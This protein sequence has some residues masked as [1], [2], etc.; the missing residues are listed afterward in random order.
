MNG[1]DPPMERIFDE[2][3][4]TSKWMER[5][6]LFLLESFSLRNESMVTN[7]ATLG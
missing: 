5:V 7:P 2:E 6:G 3:F 1:F 4:F